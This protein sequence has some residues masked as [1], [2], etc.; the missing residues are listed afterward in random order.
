V[1]VDGDQV[2]GVHG[3]TLGQQCA[4]SERGSTL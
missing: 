1:G 4:G 3:K 2:G